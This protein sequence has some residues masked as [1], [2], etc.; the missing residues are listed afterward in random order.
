V[1]AHRILIAE[2]DDLLRRFLELRLRSAGFDVVSA[3]DGAEAWS[4]Y[5]SRG[6]FA[7]VLFDEDM[8][9]L[10]GRELISRLRDQGETVAAILMSGSLTLDVGEQLALGVGPVVEKPFSPST[11]I[12]AL[13]GAIRARL[14]QLARAAEIPLLGRGQLTARRVS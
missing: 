12:K 8:P 1:A 4:L 5:S 11:L 10:T 3:A 2:D 7:A 14:D 9:A 13:E 6:P